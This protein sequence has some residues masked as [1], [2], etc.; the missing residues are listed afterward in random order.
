[1]YIIFIYDYMKYI[2]IYIYMYYII[3]FYWFSQDLMPQSSIGNEKCSST[4]VVEIC[5]HSVYVCGY[6]QPTQTYT[7]I[8]AYTRTKMGLSQPSKTAW[9]IWWNEYICC[10]RFISFDLERRTTNLV[11]CS[12]KYCG[13]IM[14][15]VLNC[16]DSGNCGFNG[17]VLKKQLSHSSTTNWRRR[18]RSI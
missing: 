15:S 18:N 1:M 17:I 6:M 2:Y 11:G 4:M 5:V 9:R 16:L 12:R 14:V 3:H 13:P 7:P 10:P 8:L